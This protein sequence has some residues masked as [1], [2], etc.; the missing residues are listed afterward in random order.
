MKQFFYQYFSFTKKERIAV[1][2]LLL[3]IA[4]CFTIPHFY[5][6]VIRKKKY[7]FKEFEMSIATLQI[8]D[9][10]S[11]LSSTVNTKYPS[12]LANGYGNK[13]RYIHTELFY[14]DPNTIDSIGWEKLGLKAKTIHTIR[15]YLLKGGHFYK[16]DDIF[17]I[18][19]YPATWQPNFYPLFKLKKMKNS[20]YLAPIS[21]QSSRM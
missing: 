7:A 17:K 16:E 6:L 10:T 5:H 11:Q 14:F 15:Q 21:T 12:S 20:K 9:S 8:K 2:S 1:F 13:E 4:L 18:W 3:L 19:G